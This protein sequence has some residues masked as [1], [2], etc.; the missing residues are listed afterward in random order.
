MKFKENETVRIIKDFD[1][2]VKKNDVGVVI[3]AFDEPREAY[4]VEILN[5]NGE[6]KKQ[7]T[8]LPDDLE[9]FIQIQESDTYN[10]SEGE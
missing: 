5:E 10:L 3:M 7:C 1:G 4:E 9:L 6:P 8:L 2:N